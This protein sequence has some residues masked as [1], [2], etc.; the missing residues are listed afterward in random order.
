MEKGR[1]PACIV[2]RLNEFERG[3]RS[4]RTSIAVSDFFRPWLAEMEINFPIRPVW[5]MFSDAEEDVGRCKV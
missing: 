3:V 4:W 2:D 5:N 1:F